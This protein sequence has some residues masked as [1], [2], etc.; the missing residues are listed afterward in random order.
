M[1][2][3]EVASDPRLKKTEKKIRFRENTAL[4][5]GLELELQLIDSSSLSLA[6]R[7][8]DLLNT[9]QDD[10]KFKREFYLTDIEIVT[11]ICDGVQALENDINQSIEKLISAG[12]KHDI[13]FSA[14]GTH[15]FTSHR[16]CPITPMNHYQSLIRRHPWIIN[17]MMVYALHVH[18]G[19]PNGEHCI[20][21][22]QAFK[23]VIPH[24]LALSG[25]S[26]F[27]EGED[28]GLCAFRPLTHEILPTAGLPYDIQSWQQYEAL[29]HLLQQSDA[30][31][32][33]RD[34]WWDL[35][36]SPE[37]GTLE[38]RVCDGLA[39]QAE[40]MAMTALIHCFAYWF[41]TNHFDAQPD[42]I[43]RENK[44]RAIR[45]GLKANII[46]SLDEGTKS[47]ESDIRDWLIKL[48]PIFEKMQY[49]FYLTT[50]Y[51]ILEN[52]TSAS[53]Q[54]M[55]FQQTHDFAAVVAFNINE[56]VLGKPI[57]LYK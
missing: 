31:H 32:S 6:P 12:K 30:I 37:L 24:L 11:N 21:M 50:L 20:K 27:W 10:P 57:W 33:P 42:W 41:Q 36:P 8:D 49:T 16:D 29:V 19:M 38:I 28:T 40:A 45:D 17:R 47:L 52:G 2:F 46:V 5:L 48:A 22:L 18:L 13:C 23:Q 39:T 55:I 3:D 53:R 7:V 51:N 26:P 4:T 9:L 14:T 35:R 44:W 25:S 43:L 34:L 56:F 1:L 54:R 15:P